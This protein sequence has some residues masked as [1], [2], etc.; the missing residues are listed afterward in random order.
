MNNGKFGRSI[1]GYEEIEPALCRMHLGN[2]D[3]E[4]ADRV[5][6][7]LLLGPLVAFDIGE[8]RNTMALK[9]SMQR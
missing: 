4:I 7:E 6:L 2:V 9:A 1:N 5:A 8:P 3:V